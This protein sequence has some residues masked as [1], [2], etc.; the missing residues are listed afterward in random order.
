[1]TEDAEVDGKLVPAGSTA[2]V[3]PFMMHRDEEEFGLN[4]EEFQPDRFLPENTKQRHFY[5]YVPFSVL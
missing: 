2:V 5:S 4:P 1:M 3:L